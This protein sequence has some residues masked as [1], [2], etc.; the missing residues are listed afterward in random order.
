MGNTPSPAKDGIWG[1]TPEEI[2][3]ERLLEESFPSTYGS[4]ARASRAGGE[5]TGKAPSARRE[6]VGAHGET[7]LETSVQGQGVGEDEARREGLDSG[8]RGERIG[9]A[10][11]GRRPVGDR[12]SGRRYRA[13]ATSGLALQEEEDRGETSPAVP[14]GKLELENR[15]LVA[16]FQ[17]ELD[18]A[19]LVETKMS[20]VGA[21]WTFAWTGSLFG[22]PS[23]SL[24]CP[25]RVG[26]SHPCR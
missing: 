22:A 12:E 1:R 26:G 2:E 13:G 24:A 20:E 7:A 8:G 16:R 19:R 3:E 5:F 4:D 11:T 6:A 21:H 17:N 23:H 25:D 10:G 14:T 18:D 15:D 9:S